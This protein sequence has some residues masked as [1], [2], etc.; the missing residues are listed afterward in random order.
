MTAMLNKKNVFIAC[1]AVAVG[2]A[3]VAVYML[4]LVPPTEPQDF[5]GVKWGTNVRDIPGLTPLAED[6]NLKFYENKSE[7]LKMED[8]DLDKVVY[9]FYKDRFYQGIIY[10]RSAAGLPKLKQ[11]L[12]RLYGD[13]IQPEQSVNKYFWNGDNVSLLLSYDEPSNAG[14]IAYLFKPIQLE[15]ELKQ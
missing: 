2:L 14:R 13:P 3:L 5:R 9:A 10:Y 1:G 12:T 15:V 4:T 6:G 7:T 11:I 8:V